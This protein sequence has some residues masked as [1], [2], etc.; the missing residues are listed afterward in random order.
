MYVDEKMAL[1]KRNKNTVSIKMKKKIKKN[2][3]II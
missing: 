2:G 3:G 1:G